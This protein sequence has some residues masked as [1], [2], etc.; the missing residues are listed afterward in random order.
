MGVHR[1]IL[2]AVVAVGLLT[3]C[4]P[5]ATPEP[6]SV[7]TASPP[8]PAPRDAISYIVAAGLPQLPL[9]D[10]TDP[11]IISLSITIGDQK[12]TVPGNIG[13]DRLRAV[14]APVHTHDDSGQVWLEG[15]GNRTV[16]LGQF[17][18]LWGVR[19]DASCLGAD[20]GTIQ[21]FAD[22]TELTGPPA[23][24]VL[25]EAQRSIQIRVTG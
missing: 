24:F 12:V 13:I 4:V 22:G 19:F 18:T 15:T 21:V 11:H 2:A 5:Q 9:N 14:Q 1:L 20:C 8:W 7:S 23:D 10:E 25:R 3:G 6:A 16:T 17:F